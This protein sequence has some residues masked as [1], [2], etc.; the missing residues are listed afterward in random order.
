MLVAHKQFK[1]WDNLEALARLCLK[2][3]IAPLAGQSKLSARDYL[4]D[5]LYFGGSDA[6]AAKDYKKSSLKLAEFVHDFKGDKR[7]DHGFFVLAFAYRGIESHEEAIVS[8]KAI[9]EEYPGS[10]YLRGALLVGGEWSTQM[11]VEEDTMYFYSKFMTRFAKD[12][13]IPEV[14]TALVDLYMG[15]K[16]Y[17]NASGIYKEM[18][19]NKKLDTVSRMNAALAYMDIEERYGDKANAMWAAGEVMKMAAN[20]HVAMAKVYALEARTNAT[21]TKSDTLMAIEHKLAALDGTNHEVVES[22]GFVRFLLALRSAEHTKQEIYNLGLTDPQ[23]T[24]EQSYALFMTS[25]KDHDQVCA[26]GSSSYCAPAMS[27]FAKLTLG[28]IKTLEE[29]K[30]QETLDEATVAKFNARKQEMMASLAEMAHTADDR[31]VALVAEGSS[32]PEWAEQISWGNSEDWSMDSISNESK[33]AFVQWA[34]SR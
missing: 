33:T 16:L 15:R 30:I 5:A 23:R 34:P 14:R 18:A 9:V 10:K 26:I 11:A 22:L 31:A 8:L 4:G 20:D 24:M 7:R 17:G 2:T 25:K 27:N 28:T 13:K 29:I 21:A 12:E 1:G 19:M 6:Y 3:N 32:S